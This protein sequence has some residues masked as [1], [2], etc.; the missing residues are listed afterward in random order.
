MFTLACWQANESAPFTHDHSLLILADQVG[1][2]GWG[3][4][5]I[6]MDIKL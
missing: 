6:I 5:Q 4:A 3:G 1:G 2:C